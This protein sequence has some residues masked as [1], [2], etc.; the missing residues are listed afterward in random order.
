[1][2]RQLHKVTAKVQ[3]QSKVKSERRKAA[4]T[5]KSLGLPRPG[6]SLIDSPTDSPA[7]SALAELEA[8]SGH[9][10]QPN[11]FCTMIIM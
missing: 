6:D 4:G 8:W 1:M 5:Y 10:G 2:F 11:K 7:A 9:L 3:A